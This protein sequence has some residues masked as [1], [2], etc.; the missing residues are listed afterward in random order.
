MAEFVRTTHG[1]IA[2][3]QPIAST[4]APVLQIHEWLGED[5]A[6]VEVADLSYGTH[7]RAHDEISIDLG[8]QYGLV[9][10]IANIVFQQP[11]PTNYVT[12]DTTVYKYDFN[13]PNSEDNS[14]HAAVIPGLTISNGTRA[15]LVDA[16]GIGPNESAGTEPGMTDD[17]SMM[18]YAWE[19]NFRG[20]FAFLG[21]GATTV[22]CSF[23]CPMHVNGVYADGSGWGGRPNSLPIANW[24]GT[25]G[26]FTGAG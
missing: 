5:Y 2:A 1:A 23:E 15:V 16:D 7:W 13:I 9:V 3:T 17:P 21:A 26:I 22:T 14:T 25:V 6:D 18:V 19:I 4:N 24:H 12:Y 10:V 20:M 11:M 8:A